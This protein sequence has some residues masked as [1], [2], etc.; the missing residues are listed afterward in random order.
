MTTFKN[1]VRVA[2]LLALTG[3]AQAQFS[4]TVT[5]A[6]EYDFR[7]ISL[8]ANDPVLQAS[9]DYAFGNG[10]AIGA[11]ASNLDYGPAYDGKT[12]LDFYGGYTGTIN[13][14]ASWTVGAV[15]YDY[16]GSDELLA[17][18]QRPVAKLQIEP[19]PEY[20]LGG[21]FG[22]VSLKQWYS[23]DFGASS[24]AGLYTEANYTQALPANWTLS[25]HAGYSYGEYWEDDGP[26]GGELF[27]YSIGLSYV[28]DRFTL[29][30]KLTATDADGDRQI[31]NDYFANNPRIVGW[32]STTLPWSK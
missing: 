28:W 19:Y 15:L 7:G 21:T 24:V 30:A 3:A 25:V 13:D 16:P 14:K 22:P 18:P 5:A 32:I 1:L 10:F 8:S 26:G 4:S 23:N 6:T 11:W 31:S 17:T 9:I 2:A 12:E 20:Y 29:G 27:D